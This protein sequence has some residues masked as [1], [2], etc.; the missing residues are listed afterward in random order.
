MHKRNKILFPGILA[1]ADIRQDVVNKRQSSNAFP[2]LQSR[3]ILE[4]MQARLRYL[5]YSP[6]TGEA[7]L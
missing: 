6:R 2:P 3:K 4:Q 1:N 5:H 7:Y